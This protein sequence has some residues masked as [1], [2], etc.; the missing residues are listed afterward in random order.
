M[1]GYPRFGVVSTGLLQK[2]RI[3]CNRV[4]NAGTGATGTG[5]FCAL[6]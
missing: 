4:S 2:F 1:G 3:L 6:S 5:A